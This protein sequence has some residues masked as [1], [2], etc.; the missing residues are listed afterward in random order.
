LGRTIF[1]VLADSK[2]GATR[3]RCA[4]SRV[5][6]EGNREREETERE[7]KRER[8][9]RER[10]RERERAPRAHKQVKMMPKRFSNFE[11]ER[12]NS[13]FLYDGLSRGHEH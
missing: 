8:E 2:A 11:S 12:R 10:E 7:R 1:H 4:C 3:I 5:E 9:R 13:G 6:R